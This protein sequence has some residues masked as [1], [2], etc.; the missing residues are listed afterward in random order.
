MALVIC[1]ECH[2]EIS[3]KA[4]HCVKCGCPISKSENVPSDALEHPSRNT[5]NDNNRVPCPSCSELVNPTA[6]ICPFCKQAILS[7]NKGTNAIANVVVSV[8]IFLILFYALNA[9]IHHEADKETARIMQ[10]A[11]RQT[12]AMMRSLQQR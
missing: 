9:F 6:T 5:V 10:D 7:K 2:S 12:D 4:T 8:V 1:P 3:D 11:Q